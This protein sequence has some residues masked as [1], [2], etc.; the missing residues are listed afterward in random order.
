MAKG[1]EK[2]LITGATGNVGSEIVKSM[3]KDKM[4][5]ATRNIEKAEKNLGEDLEY[6]VFDFMR[7][8]TYQESLKRVKKIFLVRPPKIS[9]VKEHIFPIIDRAEEC[10]VEH[11]VFL[12]L[13]GVEKNPIVPHYKIEKYIKESN[14]PFTFLR[15][16]FF[17]QNLNTTHRKDIKEND[18]IFV[19][20]GKG[21]TSFIDVR[22]IAKVGVKALVESG[23]ENEAY[24]LTGKEALN[25][26]QIAE[27]F[28]EILDREITYPNPS[29]F[30]FFRRMKKREHN[31]GFIFVMIGLYTTA[32][33]GLAKR[34]SEELQNLLDREPISIRK[35]IKD[36]R[37]EWT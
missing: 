11:I 35:Y 1:K 9:D 10:G 37:E 20:A 27:I 3:D 32:R 4:L 21:K 22:D 23:H 15:A 14:I 34:T 28:S 18:E 19:P 12:S 36:Y 30:K 31:I 33:L 5:I 16:S 8:A 17:M 25:Y 7:P 2:F 13:L 29:I 6:T 26:Y 24:D